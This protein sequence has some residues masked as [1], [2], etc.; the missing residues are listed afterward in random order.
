MHYDNECK[1]LY[2]QIQFIPALPLGI[3]WLPHSIT[4][5]LPSN[6]SAPSPAI[7]DCK[8]Y[9][10]KSFCTNTVLVMT[11]VPIFQGRYLYGSFSFIRSSGGHQNLLM[12]EVFL[13][14]MSQK[15]LCGSVPSTVSGE[16]VIKINYLILQLMP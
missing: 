8:C 3:N 16:E 6:Q 14:K 10:F 4:E 7:Y 1:L 5:T 11:C 13:G 2:L 15:Y 12:E 9:W